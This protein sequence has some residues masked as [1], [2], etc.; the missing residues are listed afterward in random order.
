[1]VSRDLEV[2]K[3]WLGLNKP[4]PAGKIVW[5]PGLDCLHD[6]QRLEGIV[7]CPGWARKLMGF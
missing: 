7:G 6:G 3:L 1:V 4:E 5:I 2:G